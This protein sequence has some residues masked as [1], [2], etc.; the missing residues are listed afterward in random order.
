MTVAEQHRDLALMILVGRSLPGGLPWTPEEDQ[1][2]MARERLLWVQLT[3]E[4]REQEQTSLAALWGKRGSL[5]SVPVNKA[6]GP[7]VSDLTSVDIPD[8]AFGLPDNHLRP[9]VKGITVLVQEHPELVALLEWLWKRGFH[10]VDCVGGTLTLLI[11]PHRI[12]QESE[13]LVGVLLRDWPSVPVRTPV[14]GA[15]LTVKGSY[16]PVTG[17][18]VILLSGVIPTDFP[19]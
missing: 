6:W 11:P 2:L 4:E 17:Q 14:T 19:S 16:D 18:A 15:S 7:W 5:R 1:V 8:T 12:V 13:R 9:F 10:P 3:E